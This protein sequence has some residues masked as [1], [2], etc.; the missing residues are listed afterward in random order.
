MLTFLRRSTRA[1]FSIKS[2]HTR[3]V[4]SEIQR[5]SNH[6][7]SIPSVTNVRYEAALILGNVLNKD[8]HHLLIHQDTVVDEKYVENIDKMVNSRSNGMPMAYILGKREFY[9]IDF[10]ISPSTLIPRPPTEIIVSKCLELAQDIPNGNIVDLGT[11][12]GCII[13]SFLK[14]KSSW[15]GIGVDF[16]KEALA[17]AQKNAHSVGVSDRIEWVQ[18]NWTENLK[19][20]FDI[21][22]SNPPYICSEDIIHLDSTVKDYEPHSALDGGQDGLDCYRSISSQIDAI[23]KSGTYVI[24]EIGAN[25]EASVLDIFHQNAPRLHPLGCFEDYEGFVRCIA[26][27]MA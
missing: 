16:S 18:S 27:K 12:S 21:I 20:T 4:K 3:T 9:S 2:Y 14:N 5:I 1:T 26:W 8:T 19:D 17:V 6:I 10:E 15:K 23:S 11:G 22:V 7:K 13:T 25:Q 24:V